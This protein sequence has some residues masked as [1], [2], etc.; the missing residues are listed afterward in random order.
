MEPAQEGH[1]GCIARYGVKVRR[2][3]IGAAPGRDAGFR[4]G[5]IEAAAAMANIEDH[6]ALFRFDRRG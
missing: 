1:A 5:E 6:A 2:N 4:Y 3:C